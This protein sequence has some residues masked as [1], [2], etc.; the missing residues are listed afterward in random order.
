[1][2][3]MPM[4][5]M[6]V[7]VLIRFPDLDAAQRWL[8]SA[9]DASLACQATRQ[10]DYSALWRLEIGSFALL[11]LETVDYDKLR[12]AC[13]YRRRRYGERY[14]IKRINDAYYTV[15]RKG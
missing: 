8:D 9:L 1:M 14:A 15:T 2:P 12:H 3:A 7:D 6:P 10:H 4:P 5:A 11:A 13:Q